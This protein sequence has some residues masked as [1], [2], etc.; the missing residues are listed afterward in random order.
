MWQICAMVAHWSPVISAMAMLPSCSSVQVLP[1]VQLLP[2][3]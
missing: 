3:R 1:T 2:W